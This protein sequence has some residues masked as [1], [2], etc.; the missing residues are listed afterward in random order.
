MSDSWDDRRKAIE[1]GY[2]KKQNDAALA[3]LK[4]R[5]EAEAPRKSPVTGEDMIQETM[6]GVVIDRCPT[7]G[8]IY[9][10]PGEFEQ[11]L[12]NFNE[13]KEDDNFLG[14]ILKVFKP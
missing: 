9:L 7:T 11:L 10:D 5:T 14:S 4:A 12:E 13:N 1:E 3:R 2:F 6:M 8:G